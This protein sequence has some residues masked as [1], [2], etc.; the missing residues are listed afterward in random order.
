MRRCRN[1]GS[2]DLGLNQNNNSKEFSKVAEYRV[3][4]Q[5]PTVRLYSSTEKSE[6]EIK[7]MIPLTRASKRI[8]VLGTKLTKEV[9]NLRYEN[10]RTLLN[11]IKEDLNKGASSCVPVLNT[12][13]NVE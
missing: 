8:K 12:C 13:N 6:S 2:F 3:N 10:S 11:V 9:P 7:E 4:I 1:T 5:N